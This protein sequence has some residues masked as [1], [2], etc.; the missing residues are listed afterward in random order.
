MLHETGSWHQ[1]SV[2]NRQALSALDPGTGSR[3][4]R[5]QKAVDKN[6][7]GARQAAGHIIFILPDG[8]QINILLSTLNSNYSQPEVLFNHQKK[9]WTGSDYDLFTLKSTV[10]IM[11]DSLE[12]PPVIFP[13]V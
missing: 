10:H 1:Y 2:G 4:Q 11:V 3:E 7:T 12:S 9:W 5:E 8:C 6:T 13:H